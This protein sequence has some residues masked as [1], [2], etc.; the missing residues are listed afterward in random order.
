MDG[1]PYLFGLVLII[2]MD[3][4]G[5][6]TVLPDLMAMLPAMLYVMQLTFYLFFIWFSGSIAMRGYRKVQS[7]AIGTGIRLLSGVICLVGGM[8][9]AGFVPYLSKG[10]LNTL[11]LDMLVAG[12]ILSAI[13]ALAFRMI[14]HDQDERGPRDAVDSLRRK[15]AI[16]EDKLR[17]GAKALTEKDA[18]KKAEAV[19]S[20]YKALKARM[21]GN[22]WEIDLKMGE[23]PGKIIIDAWDG[24]IKKKVMKLDMSGFFK[25]S[26]KVIGLILVIAVVTVS[27]AFF[28]GFP[29]PTESFTSIFGM[30]MD[31][32]GDLA[33]SIRDNP[34]ISGDLTEGCVSPFVFNR[35]QT[36]LSDKDYLLDHLHEDE[37]AERTVEASSGEPVQIMIKIDH[38]GKELVLAVTDAGKGCYFT[39]G[40]FC[41]CI[42]SQA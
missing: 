25:D 15:V 23:T 3:M 6:V 38:E 26:R 30:S 9:L 36:K 4:S 29:D 7:M 18:I 19:M 13:L 42:A 34:F 16:L 2:L 10:V 32:I 11:Q 31:D 27:L 37:V 24:E 35:Y 20:G 41:G 39:D 28:E 8:S 1:L 22:E 12:L 33:A 40:I 21:I 5:L 14:T 17:S